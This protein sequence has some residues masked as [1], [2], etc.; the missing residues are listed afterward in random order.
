MDLRQHNLLN[1]ILI[2]IMVMLPLRSVIAS[3]R[4]TCDMHEQA[5]PQDSGHHLHHHQVM[6]EADHQNTIATNDECCCCEGSI[7]CHANCSISLGAGVIMPPALSVPTLNVSSIRTQVASN[8]VFR[9]RIPPI[10]PPA[11]L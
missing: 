2:T 8:P 4:S 9:E 10:R 3:D 6:G 7:S 1:W 11:Y 5:S